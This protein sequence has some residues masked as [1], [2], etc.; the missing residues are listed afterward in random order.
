M[1]CG[2][3]DV[4]FKK[5]KLHDSFFGLNLNN[6]HTKASRFKALLPSQSK[7]WPNSSFL[8]E[9]IVVSFSRPN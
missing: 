7:D 1:E 9:L 6:R 3:I 5:K 2:K 4:I 8:I